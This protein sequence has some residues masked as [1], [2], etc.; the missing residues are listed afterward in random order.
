V[1]QILDQLAH[2]VGKSQL[3]RRL[4]IGFAADQPGSEFDVSKGSTTAPSSAGPGGCQK[5]RQGREN[6]PVS[7]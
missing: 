4:A 1:E 2:L 5:L 3:K 7:L 6:S